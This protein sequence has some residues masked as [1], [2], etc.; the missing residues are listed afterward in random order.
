MLM[1]AMRKDDESFRTYEEM[2]D[3]KIDLLQHGK[4]TAPANDCD[5]NGQGKP[6]ACYMY[7]L[8]MAEVAVETATGKTTVEKITLGRY[9]KINTSWSSMVRSTAVSLRVSVW[10]CPKITRISRSTPP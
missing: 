8:C 9:R 4:W 10:P 2:V 6:F 5:E 3:E 7:G 1:K